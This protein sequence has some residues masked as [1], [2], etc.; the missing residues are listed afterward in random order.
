MKPFIQRTT[1]SP[2]HAHERIYCNGWQRVYSTQ[3]TR[4]INEPQRGL[5]GPTTT[6]YYIWIYTFTKLTLS[7][8]LIE[9]WGLQSLTC[10][11]HRSLANIV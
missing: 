4:V 9:C 1:L 7:Q 3:S 5:K 8:C 11:A 10:Y 2:C 6:T